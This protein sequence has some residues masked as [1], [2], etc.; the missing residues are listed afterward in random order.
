[1]EYRF[2]FPFEKITSGSKILIYGAGILGQEYLKQLLITGY[3]QCVGFL[4][5]N[6][7]HYPD[8][9]VPVYSPK[10]AARL[11][12]DFIVIA[13]RGELGLNEILRTLIGM[14]ISESRIV[15]VLERN[16]PVQIFGD[17]GDILDNLELAYWC[18]RI[19]FAI[20]V[21]GGFGDMIIQKRLI[22]ELNRL[23][24]AATIDLYTVHGELFLEWLYSD[25]ESVKNIVTDLG[26]RYLTQKENYSF[27]FRIVGSGFLEI[28]YRRNSDF[29]PEFE[30]FVHKLELLQM[31]CEDEK[32][33]VALPS[34][35]M[36][37][38]RI[39]NG[40]NCYSG[41]NYG[42]VFSINDFHVTIPFLKKYKEAFLELGLHDYITVNVGNGISADGKGVAKA[43]PFQ[44]FHDVIDIFKRQYP[45]VSVVQIGAAGE[46]LLDNADMH[47]MGKA[48]GLIA[49]VLRSAIFHFDIEGGIVH[50][51]SQIGVKCIVLFGPTP[52]AYYAYAHNTNISVGMCRDCYG[53]YLDT[54]RC[55]RNM[56]EPE[57]MY[58]ISVELV[59]EKI[60]DYMKE[61]R[62]K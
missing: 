6:Y 26:V 55:A 51:A 8:M 25:M 18:S 43:W 21:A 9:R 57:C 40:E 15:Y 19:S 34:A 61:R 56:D 5:K 52:M 39:F 37:Y 33:S 48:F 60:A 16:A 4:D 7:E 62:S 50:L 53:Y 58:G 29:L 27:A 17:S 11:E 24:P 14:G 44:R 30:A 54:N 31:K 10:E 1:M 22:M 35:I 47:L 49:Y 28:D 46:K 42:G 32:Y 20:Y 36:F 23:V 59:M 38:R 12:F 45:G 41:F 3:C 2:L 13:L